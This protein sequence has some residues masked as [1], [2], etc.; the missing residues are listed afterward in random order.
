VTAGGAKI[1]TAVPAVVVSH[2]KNGKGAYTVL[3]TQT[4]SG[5][6]ADEQDN[7]LT[8]AGNTMANPDFVY[9]PAIPGFDDEVV[10]IAPGVLFSRMIRA[11][12]LP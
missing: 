7:Q 6:D 9:K 2:G 8:G 1:A 4:A 5:A 11:G 10:W 12:K 3:G